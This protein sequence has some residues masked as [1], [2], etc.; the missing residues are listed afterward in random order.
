MPIEKIE[1]DVVSHEYDEIKAI[2]K[3]R[4]WKKTKIHTIN[5]NNTTN[6]STNVSKFESTHRISTKLIDY[7]YN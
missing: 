5:L 6:I 7:Y 4:Q 1:S 3:T 2:L